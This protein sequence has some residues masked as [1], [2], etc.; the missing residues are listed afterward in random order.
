M[1]REIG[2]GE[3]NKVADRLEKEAGEKVEMANAL[4]FFADAQKIRREL[5]STNEALE[6]KIA[7]NKERYTESEG[8]LKAIQLTVVSEEEKAEAKVAKVQSEGDV[9][10]KEQINWANKKVEEISDNLRTKERDADVTIEGYKKVE[11]E[12]SR[13]AGTAVAKKEEAEAALNAVKDKILA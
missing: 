3:L 13:K 10:V 2:A 6:R 8:E 11:D 1:T 9:R 12:A 5:A 7:Q 4:R